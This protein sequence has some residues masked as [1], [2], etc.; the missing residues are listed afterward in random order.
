MKENYFEVWIDFGRYLRRLL[1]GPDSL[2]VIRSGFEYGAY[3]GY[4][5]MLLAFLLVF[6]GIRSYRDNVSGGHISFGRAFAV[7]IS[8]HSHFLRLYVIRVGGRLLHNL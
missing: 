6:F 7:G 5:G 2:R 4:T 3:F 1:P 8:N